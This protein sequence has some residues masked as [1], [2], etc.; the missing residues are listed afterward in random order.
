MGAGNR[1]IRKHHRLTRKN[2]IETA[3]ACLKPAVSVAP[4]SVASPNLG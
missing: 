3:L 1:L 4:R 2:I